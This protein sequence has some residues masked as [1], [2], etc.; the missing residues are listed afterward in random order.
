MPSLK[1]FQEARRRHQKSLEQSLQRIVELSTLDDPSSMDAL[2]QLAPCVDSKSMTEIAGEFEEMFGLEL[3]VRWIQEGGY[4]DVKAAVND[5]LDKCEQ[6]LAESS[7][8]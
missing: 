2:E 3:H 8:D 1:E 7:H 6:E 5:I 4:S